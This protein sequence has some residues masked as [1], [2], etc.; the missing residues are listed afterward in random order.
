[1]VALSREWVTPPGTMCYRGYVLCRTVSTIASPKNQRLS[2]TN[3]RFII[4]VHGCPTRGR[5]LPQKTMS[6]NI[7][8]VC[9]RLSDYWRRG[10]NE[11]RISGGTTRGAGLQT[12]DFVKENLGGLPWN[13]SWEGRYSLTGFGSRLRKDGT[14]SFHYRVFS[15]PPLA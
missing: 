15:S 10:G 11:H 14:P 7:L 9:K 13:D 1:M 5:M 6:S 2:L 12:G 8:H 3:E 4:M